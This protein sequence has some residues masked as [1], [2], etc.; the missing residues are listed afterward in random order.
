MLKYIYLPPSGDLWR[1]LAINLRDQ[2]IATPV[3]WMGH[4]KSDQFA[5][6]NFPDCNVINFNET[7]KGI[8]QFKDQE[9][10]KHSKYCQIL[11]EPWFLELKDQ[12]MRM[13]D[14][15]DYFGAFRPVDREAAFYNLIFRFYTIIEKEKPDVLIVSESPHF[16]STLIVYRICEY[17]EIPIV[18]Y[19]TSLVSPA[20]FIKSGIDKPPIKLPIGI[21]QN[22]FLQA[23]H[24][25]IDGMIYNLLNGERNPQQP[26]YMLRQFKMERRKRVSR[27]L[28]AFRNIF[29]AALSPILPASMQTRSHYGFHGFS[30]F[31]N[32]AG[33][34]SEAIKYITEVRA[35]RALTKAYSEICT[36][37]DSLPEKYAFFPLHYEPERTS[38]PD[39]GEWHNQYHAIARLRQLLPDDVAIVVKEHPSQL[40]SF[41][42]GFRG[43]SRFSYETISAIKGVFFTPIDVP[44]WR[45]QRNA[46]LTCTLTGTAAL[47]AAITGKPA[48]LMGHSWFRGCPGITLLTDAVSFEDVLNNTADIEDIRAYLYR[49]ID[50]YSFFGV[51]APSQRKYFAKWFADSSSMERE[52]LG[53]TKATI[54]AIRALTGESDG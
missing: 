13:L 23:S 19:M 28:K 42:Q 1:K 25:E 50:E 30:A 4:R 24:K 41:V 47:E 34:V 54:Y 5:R 46:I 9:Y 32:H 8:F 26:G 40:G 21:D 14:R 17:M 22:E 36:S 2:R 39:G 18:C 12:A 43:R 33:I 45:I 53:L 44:S 49:L 48:V 37:E 38:N 3:L 51:I 15:N 6:E 31:N 10:E 52:E 20:I 27:L 35:Q 11:R 29:R 16:A 7:N